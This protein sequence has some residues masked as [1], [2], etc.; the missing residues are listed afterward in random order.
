M[1]NAATKKRDKTRN[2][3]RSN[4]SFLIEKAPNESANTYYIKRRDKKSNFAIRVLV[5]GAENVFFQKRKQS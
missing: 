4:P 2:A 3:K 5:P 1:T